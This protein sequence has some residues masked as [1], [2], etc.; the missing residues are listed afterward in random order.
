M[1]L[2]FFEISEQEEVELQLQALEYL[3]I[4]ITLHKSL[5]SELATLFTV[6]INLLAYS[7]D[8]VDGFKAVKLAILYLMLKS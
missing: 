3:F 4:F 6:I 5:R 7:A 1:K 8:I 2:F